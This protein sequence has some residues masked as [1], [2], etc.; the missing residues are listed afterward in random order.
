MKIE[1][2][3]NFLVVCLCVC[4]SVC[5]THVIIIDKIDIQEKKELTDFIPNL[6]LNEGKNGQFWN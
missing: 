4:V 6:F 5:I 3:V 1:R 2:S